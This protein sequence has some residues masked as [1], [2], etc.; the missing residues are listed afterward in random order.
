[1]YRVFLLYVIAVLITWG[2]AKKERIAIFDEKKAFSS[3]H[4]SGVILSLKE[5]KEGLLSLCPPPYS[6]KGSISSTFKDT[7]I[8]K[9]SEINLE[10]QHIKNK[11]YQK[12]LEDL[13]KEK[14]KKIKD[15]V[16]EKKQEKEGE[17]IP[18]ND[19]EEE[20]YKEKIKAKKIEVEKKYQPEEINTKLKLQTLRHSEGEKKKLENYLRDLQ[21]QKNNELQQEIYQIKNKR[22]EVKRQKEKEVK[23][24]LSEY[25]KELQDNLEKQLEEIKQTGGQE[26][27]KIKKAKEYIISEETRQI[28]SY[29]S[30]HPAEEFDCQKQIKI[31]DEQIKYLQKKIKE[32]VDLIAKKIAKKKNL[33]WEKKQDAEVIDITEEVIKKLNP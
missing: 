14:E 25:Q 19:G 12:M 16:E 2:C 27:D 20:K 1:M 23:C 3:H 5:K 28:K 4:L 10:Y 7:L 32:D 18:E 21:N 11:E 26:I 17:I 33:T 8:R 22:E 24:L 9:I 30:D 13:K 31:I 29:L 15:K 6:D